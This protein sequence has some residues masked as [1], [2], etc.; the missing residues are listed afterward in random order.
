LMMRSPQGQ[1]RPF[2]RFASPSLG[3]C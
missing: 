3:V 1:Q 2:V